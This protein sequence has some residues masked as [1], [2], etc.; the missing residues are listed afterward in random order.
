M[1]HRYSFEPVRAA[2]PRTFWTG[3]LDGSGAPEQMELP[4]L[5]PE[6]SA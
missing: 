1:L 2:T 5:Q 3:Y 6:V 4:G